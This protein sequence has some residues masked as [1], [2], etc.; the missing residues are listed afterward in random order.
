MS[1]PTY[2]VAAIWLKNDICNTEFLPLKEVLA[3]SLKSFLHEKSPEEI[4]EVTETL[5]V[6]VTREMKNNV[7]DDLSDGVQSRVVIEGDDNDAYIKI[8]ELAELSLLTQLRALTPQQFEGVC[9]QILNKLG[10]TSERVELKED[11]GVDF[12]GY[13]LKMG[14]DGGPAPE[15]SRVFIVGQAKCYKQK[16]LVK[17]SEIKQ[18]VGAALH[19]TLELKKTMSG[20]LGGLTPI[21]YAFWITSD[22]HPDAKKYAKELGIWYLNGIGLAQLAQRIGLTDLS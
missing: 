2:K 16:N 15:S 22:F 12:I 6:R 7:A 19:K 1:L 9:V 18:F 21:A 17:E 20:K 11:R 14:I 4:L 13:D 8:S 5:F 10:A 3:Q